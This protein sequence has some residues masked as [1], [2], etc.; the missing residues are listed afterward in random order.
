MK[1]FFSPRL[2]LSVCLTLL[3][4]CPHIV[5]AKDLQQRE[6]PPLP[7]PIA[8]DESG[9][10][11]VPVD[12]QGPTTQ[13]YGGTNVVPSRHWW[14]AGL[15]KSSNKDYPICGG[16][17]IALD[18]VLTAAHCVDSLGPINPA[19]PGA[20]RAQ[21]VLGARDRT[22][23]SS[24]DHQYKT[25]IA[26]YKSPLNN[27]LGVNTFDI[28]LLQIVPA[29]AT[30]KVAP[31]GI[32]IGSD[33]WPPT[34]TV[35]SILG[36]GFNNDACNGTIPA[37]LQVASV[38]VVSFPLTDA[39][40]LAGG[41]GVHP[42]YGDSGGGFTTPVV[43]SCPRG[44]PTVRICYSHRVAGVESIFFRYARISYP[45]VSAWICAKTNGTVQGCDGR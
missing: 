34:G 29:Q 36:W 18:W 37:I 44:T 8:I 14:H 4:V 38:T 11:Q 22:Q 27:S 41:P 25:V 20:S 17:L 39:V 32:R 2:L 30:S 1:H 21:V 10:S 28:A 43:V 13:I 42:C 40:L 16:V 24:S 31:I 33:P 19:D 23:T 9:G 26:A 5:E 12:Q 45:P 7:T 15:V 6:P 3:C 35:G